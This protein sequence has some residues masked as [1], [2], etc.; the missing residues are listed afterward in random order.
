MANENQVIY[1]AMTT[2]ELK[3]E[4]HKPVLITEDRSLILFALA[5]RH[6]DNI[7]SAPAQV[8]SEIKEKA[9]KK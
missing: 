4:L 7:D 6:R 3:N 2:E 1:D 8:Q 9:V 5:K